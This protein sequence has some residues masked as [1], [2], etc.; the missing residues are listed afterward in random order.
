MIHEGERSS[1]RDRPLRFRG[2]MKMDSA[3]RTRDATRS[4]A[5]R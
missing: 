2:P 1:T 4:M 3:Q 5:L